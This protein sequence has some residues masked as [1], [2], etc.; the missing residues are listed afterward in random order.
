MDSVFSS[1]PS[2]RYEEIVAQL[3]GSFQ[4]VIISETENGRD[5]AFDNVID[6]QDMAS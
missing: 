2:K 5:F 6:L 3:K 1:V 4:F